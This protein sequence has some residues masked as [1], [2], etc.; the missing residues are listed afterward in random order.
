MKKLLLLTLVLM[1]STIVILAEKPIHPLPVFNAVAVPCV[2]NG[3]LTGEFN[4]TIYAYI[5]KKN[6]RMYSEGVSVTS[7]FVVG[8][9]V[10]VLWNAEYG[11]AWGYIV[12]NET[13][14]KWLDCGG[15]TFG[16]HDDGTLLGWNSGFP[17]LH[18]IF[19]N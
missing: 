14:G 15:N 7:P 12:V 2:L 10:D 9:S 13:Q 16:V 19:K 8:N 11:Q 18:P 1:V 5:D 4:Y 17:K 3:D 6:G